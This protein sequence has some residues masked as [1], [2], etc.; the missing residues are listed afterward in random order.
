VDD[1]VT[2]RPGQE[3]RIAVLAN[4][5]DPDGDSLALVGFDE[6]TAR[7]AIRREGD[8]VIFTP[9][10]KFAGSETFHYTVGDHYGGRSTAP[11]PRHTPPHLAGHAHTTSQ[12]P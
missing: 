5:S 8:A 4:D 7:G 12:R 3:V 9:D 11:P 10:D 1:S 6:R 2:V